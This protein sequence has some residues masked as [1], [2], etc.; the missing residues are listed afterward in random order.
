VASEDI[1]ET[2]NTCST[3][4]CSTIGCGK[5]AT[6][7]CPNCLK[8]NI[9]TYFCS[10]ECFKGSWAIHKSI[11]SKPTE[12]QHPEIFRGFHCTGP[13]RCGSVSP[14]KIVPQ[15]IQRPEYAE[16][17]RAPKEEKA[18]SSHSIEIKTPK[19]IQLMRQACKLGREV[20][21][22]AGK[23]IRV[24]ITTDEIDKI[25]H[26]A[27]IERDCYPSPLNYY[28]FPKS[29][30]TSVNEVICHGIPDSRPL[31][32]GDIVNVDITVYYKGYHGDLNETYLVGEV[33]PE[34]LALV[35]VTRECLEKAIQ[36]VRPG[37]FYRDIGNVISKH[38][39]SHGFSV[40]RT[41]CGHG[42]GELFHAAPSIPHYGKN[43]AIGVM[44]PGHIFTIEPMINQGGWN[45]VLWPDGWTAVTKDGKRSA[46][47][48]HTLLVTENGVDVLTA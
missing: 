19:Q 26:E 3:N 23:S 12:S 17:G 4:I 31:Q 32:N 37:T 47:F 8:L 45:D 38:A 46:Q 29:C 7:R 34:S 2:T 5:P 9:N 10:Q 22:I 30:C 18:K 21:D 40:V 39:Q 35:N 33:D 28:G 27:I 43:K 48:E 24:G 25:V 42:I 6:L 15:H 41:Y 11:H 44:K 1:T 36:I 16:T 13:L 14:Q 20:L